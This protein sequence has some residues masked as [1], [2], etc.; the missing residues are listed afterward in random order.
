MPNCSCKNQ[1]NAIQNALDHLS[2][3]VSF[4]GEKLMEEVDFQV[5]IGEKMDDL[6][7]LKDRVEIVEESAEIV[8]ETCKALNNQL[9][10]FKGHFSV[11]EARVDTNERVPQR[12]PAGSGTPD[13]GSLLGPVER[14]RKYTEKDIF[15]SS[16]SSSEEGSPV[17]SFVKGNP[18][19]KKLSTS[20]I[21]RSW[22][23][24]NATTADD[25]TT[26]VFPKKIKIEDTESDEKSNAS[27]SR[28]ALF[29]E[30]S[31]VSTTGSGSWMDGKKTVFKSEV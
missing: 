22:D 13:Q 31:T 7:Q 24:G 25:D 1:I 3:K 4:L 30:E 5:K 8:D 16:S 28:K 11:L 23:E 6:Q 15:P 18:S 12:S 17:T 19:S 9:E 29:N 14:R 10:A 20:P 2:G 27:R 21:E 26:P